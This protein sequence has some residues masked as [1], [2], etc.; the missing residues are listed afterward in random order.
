MTE[1]EE[2]KIDSSVEK[3][4]DWAK[5]NQ[6]KAEQLAM[7]SARLLSC[8]SERINRLAKQGFFKRCWSRFTGEAGSIERANEKDLIEILDP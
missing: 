4:M 6:V 5:S 8:S 7:D 1:V 3:M 2:R